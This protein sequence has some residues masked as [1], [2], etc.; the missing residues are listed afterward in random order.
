MAGLTPGL[1]L[2]NTKPT[3]DDKKRNITLILSL[4]GIVT[5]ILF[6]FV[7]LSLFTSQSFSR[8]VYLHLPPFLKTNYLVKSYIIL[9]SGKLR[10]P[11]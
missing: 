11:S 8:K 2:L 1:S 6:V 9:Y 7:D 3:E 10:S 5:R 4:Q